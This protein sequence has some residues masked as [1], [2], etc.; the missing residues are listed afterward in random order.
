MYIATDNHMYRITMR[1]Y[2]TGSAAGW[3]PDY[4]DEVIG[5]ILGSCFTGCVPGTDW[6]ILPARYGLPAIIEAMRWAARKD[7]SGESCSWTLDEVEPEDIP[8]RDW[9]V[10]DCIDWH[11][12]HDWR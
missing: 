2:G 3:S 4:A 10:L 12:P 11:E 9:T 8:E 7:Y 6:H 1:E 5:G